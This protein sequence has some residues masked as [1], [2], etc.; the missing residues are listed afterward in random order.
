[1]AERSRSFSSLSSSTFGY[2]WTYD[3]F[4]N[5]RGEDTR[6]DFVR[7]LYNALDQ[8]SI[9]TFMDD[10]GLRRGEKITPAL[11]NAISESRIAIIVLSRNYASSTFCLDGL[12]QILDCIKGN[13]RLV[14]PVFYNVEPSEVRHQK[15]IY[16]EAFAQYDTRFQNDKDKVQKWRKALQDVADIS[17]F[18][19][20]PGQEYESGFIQKIVK[21]V[22]RRIDREP[23][24]VAHYPV[25]LESRVLQVNSLLDVQS[26]GV[27]MVGI[28]GMGGIGKSTIARA[29]YNLIAGRFDSSSF[30]ANVRED[31]QKHG[32]LH[33]QQ[34]LLYNVI[35]EIINVGDVD[36]GIPMIKRKLRKKKVLIVLDD[37]DKLKQLHALAGGLNWLCSGSRI[38]ITT[39]DKHLLKTHGV[40]KIYDV[41]SLNPEEALELLKW[42]AFKQNRAE[43]SY[44]D[45]LDNVVQYA[46]GLPLALEV[47]GSNLFNRGINYWNSALDE[48]RLI[49]DQNI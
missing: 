5:F 30:L 2:E 10:R 22:S 29:V 33:L 26:E 44:M 34:K 4:L 8:R 9:D 25:G 40:N 28:C 39:R 45:K 38:I 42:N 47:L 12:V 7:N 46:S 20:K 11:L 13:G 17:G 36:Q 18:T 37:V 48:W 1:M 41:E 15:E 21:E 3:V 32:L 19:F 23:L 49:P 6:F 35:G 27:Q 24:H 16:G 43:Q 31:S 14:L